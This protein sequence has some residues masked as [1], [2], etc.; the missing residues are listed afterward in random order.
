[1][2]LADWLQ[3]LSLVIVAATVAITAWQSRHVAAQ[4]RE[5]TRQSAL[6][7]T[8]L[9]Q[10]AHQT[11]VGH[12]A[13]YLSSMLSDEPD[14][15][16]WFLASRG[17]PTGDPEANKRYMILFQRLEVHE[18]TYLS[19][20]RGLLSEDVWRGWRRVIELDAATPEF[21]VVWPIVADTYSR[22]FGGFV[23]QVWVPAVARVSAEAA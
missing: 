6:A 5:V 7:A 11:L 8:A 18:T 23:A 17:L 19:Y 1:M 9:G 3:T 10:A 21:T 22:R 16:A 13:G 12:G 20:V 2:S 4:S 14:L 15:L